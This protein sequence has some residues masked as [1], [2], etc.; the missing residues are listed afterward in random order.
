MFSGFDVGFN[1][2]FWLFVGLIVLLVGVM[3]LWI[4]VWRLVV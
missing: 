4:S 2:A 1:C 3:S